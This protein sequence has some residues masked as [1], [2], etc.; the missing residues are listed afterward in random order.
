MIL[1][2]LESGLGASC[3]NRGVSLY[4]YHA[5]R[6]EPDLLDTTAAHICHAL[7]DQFSVIERSEYEAYYRKNN[8]GQLDKEFETYYRKERYALRTSVMMRFV[9]TICQHKNF[10]QSTNIQVFVDTLIQGYKRLGKEKNVWRLTQ[11][12]ANVLCQEAIYASVPLMS[13]VREYLSGNSQL[14]DEKIAGIRAL[15]KPFEA[16]N[17]LLQAIISHRPWDEN[18]VIAE[19]ELTALSSALMAKPEQGGAGLDEKSTQEIMRHFSR[20]EELGVSR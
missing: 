10:D 17:K 18:V 2:D 16:V 14:N 6:A 12:D 15:F 9:H 7:N 8:N 1:H 4:L 20:A 5:L 3:Q 13:R 19:H 11:E